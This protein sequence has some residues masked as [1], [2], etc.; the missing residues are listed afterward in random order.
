MS[1]STNRILPAFIVVL[2]A[3]ATATPAN[4]QWV[5]VG[6]KVV[7]KVTSL[8]QSRDAKTPGV[9]AA[10]VI[11]EADAGKV[12]EAAV[13]IV[14]KNP[15]LSLLKKDDARLTLSFRQGDWTLQLSVAELG[16]HV[17]QLLIVSGAGP[18]SPLRRRPPWRPSSASAR[19]WA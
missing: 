19:R 15:K 1:E 3:L 13:D 9:E 14:G 2:A 5:F 17:C 7:G 16:D 6:R 11:L 8:T 18:A 4:A 10:T 12:Y